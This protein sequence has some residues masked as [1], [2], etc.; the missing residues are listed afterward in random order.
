[1]LQEISIKDFAIIDQLEVNF[2]SGMTVL[3]G[4]TGAGKSIIIDAVGLLAGGRGSSHFIRK[5][6]NK[7]ILQG[8]F[9]IPTDGLT[10]RVLDKFGI[11]HDDDT[12]ILQ[13]ELYRNGRNVCRINGMLVN[14]NT[15]K[16]VGETLVDIYGQNEHQALMQ[17]DKHI[18]LLDE[19]AGSNLKPTL[20]KYRN[21]Y[22]K[23]LKLKKEL[24]SKN[25]NEKEWAQRI[26]ML[27]YQVNEIEAADLTDGEEEDLIAERDRL[28]NF[29]AISDSLGRSFN[30][31]NGDESISPIDMIGDAMSALEDV[32][33]LDDEFKSISENVKNAYY[34]LQDASGEI[35]NQIDT[36][37]FDPDRLNEV[38]QR[39]NTIFELK[40]KYGDSI[41]Q[42]LKYYDKISGELAEMESD[43]K[44]G[45]NLEERYNA[46]V[47]ELNHLGK[48]LSKI[49]HQ[50]A[51]KLTTEIHQQ[52]ADLYMDKT[53]FEVR[54]SNLPKDTFNRNG[55]EDV[56]FY[57][58]TNPGED[59]APLAKIAS[60]GELSRIM[61]A[62]K[63]IF[64]RVQG[65]TSIVF[66]EVDTGV[67]G[68]VAQAIADKISAIG[69]KSQV[70]CITHLPQVAAM[71]DNHD[72]ISKHVDAN[73]RTETS[74]QPLS[75]SE[76]VKELARMLAGTTVT[77]LTMEHASELL[78]LAN[79]QKDQKKK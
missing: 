33:R 13:R 14:T 12:V 65:V 10:A 36:L 24:N 63:T 62:L 47:D 57:I 11:D 68:R 53:Q 59:M 71:A 48:E 16:Q 64:S 73:N 58:R 60:G 75:G 6:A 5:G 35:S 66:D 28:N 30:D 49:R 79:K 4:E 44:S 72:F 78:N 40:R 8:M 46:A 29:Q 42:I 25:K 27:K 61:L 7:S 74:V 18:G 17:P 1:M 9:A 15:L 37:E 45:N 76:R 55:I 51:E 52:L 54:F 50:Q 38:E 56:E 43:E 19:F 26:D 32:E 23:Y 31:I 77:K 70:L 41:A 20:K 69:Q 3:S 22:E 39:L 21:K 34:T 2:Y 67:S